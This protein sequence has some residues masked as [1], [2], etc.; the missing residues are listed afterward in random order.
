MKI[1]VA[2]LGTFSVC[3]CSIVPLHTLLLDC[4]VYCAT[5]HAKL[6]VEA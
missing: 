4:K 6:T 2:D 5:W 1:L 3:V